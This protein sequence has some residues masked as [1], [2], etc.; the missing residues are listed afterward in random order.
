MLEDSNNSK[1]VACLSSWLVCSVDVWEAEGAGLPSQNTVVY[2]CMRVTVVNVV[3]GSGVCKAAAAPLGG[4]VQSVRVLVKYSC[5][6]VMFVRGR[7]LM[8]GSERVCPDSEL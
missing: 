3:E 5:T 8:I 6:N 1:A 7:S 2:V 4:D